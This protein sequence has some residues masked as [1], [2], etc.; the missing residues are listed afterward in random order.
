MESA[1]NEI[2]A[3]EVDT[4]AVEKKAP[5]RPKGSKNKPPPPLAPHSTA[6]NEDYRHAD[7]AAI[8]SR[9]MT[10]LDWAQQMLRHE[11]KKV[12]EDPNAELWPKQVEKLEKMSNAIVRSIE[13]MK[14]HADLAEE[15]AKRMTPEQLFEAAIK[16][17]E[18]Q[19]VATINAVIKRLRYYR[20]QIAPVNG[21]D[22]VTMGET[23]A[24]SAAIA[25]LEG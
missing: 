19:D 18:G 14:K 2:A 22:K 5:G 15:M 13:A 24:A 25:E 12:Y 23:K 11:I 10:L 17:I 16:K 9:Q 7:P 8:I 20:S 3:L 21:W 6:P 1:R 4:S